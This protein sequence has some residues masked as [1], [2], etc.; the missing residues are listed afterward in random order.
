MHFVLAHTAA[1]LHR[2][3]QKPAGLKV[4]EVGEEGEVMV[5]DTI[6]KLSFGGG[7]PQ[8]SKQHATTPNPAP[9]FV[10]LLCKPGL[11][12]VALLGLLKQFPAA[13]CPVNADFAQASGSG[14]G[15]TGGGS[16]SWARD[17]Q[18]GSSAGAAAGKAN[19]TPE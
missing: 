5:D 12:K 1:I 14:G 13:K 11:D 10:C 9:S 3:S 6:I 7:G 18:P 4:A 15:G 19:L 17:G 2:Q 16:K 8:H